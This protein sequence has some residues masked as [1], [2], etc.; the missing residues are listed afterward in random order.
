MKTGMLWQDDDPSSTLEEKV[1]RAA[2]YFRTKYG[3]R[4][5]TCLVHHSAFADVK[6]KMLQ[7]DTVTVRVGHPILAT[8]YWIGCEDIETRVDQQ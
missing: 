1:R 3:Y 5:D 4:P 7:V 6:D 2:K 8:T